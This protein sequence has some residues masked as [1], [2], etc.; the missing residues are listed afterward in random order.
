[1]TNSPTYKGKPLDG[2]VGT[3]SVPDDTAA[4]VTTH[5][6]QIRVFVS[7]DGVSDPGAVGL[8]EDLRLLIQGFI[9][10]SR[11]GDRKT[12]PDTLTSDEDGGIKIGLH[13]LNLAKEQESE[14]HHL[15][16]EL[17]RKRVAGEGGTK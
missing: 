13:G 7:G 9:H 11:S 12:S 2:T 8:D 17:I 5:K 16:R 14:L 1:M 3:V 15:I 6:S 4:P 10:R